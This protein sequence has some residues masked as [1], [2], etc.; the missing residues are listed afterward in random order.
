MCSIIHFLI[1][2]H[3]AFF[4]SILSLA[5]RNQEVWYTRSQ[6][7]EAMIPLGEIVRDLRNKRK[8]S[9]AQ[10]AKKIG[11]NSSTIA[12]YET[13][14][15]FPSLSALIALS[16]AL[17]VSTDYLLGVSKDEAVFLDFSGLTI[18][19]IASLNAIIENYRECNLNKPE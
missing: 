3:S 4:K 10:L 11:V 7:G 13:G 5:I 2:Y 14:E 18:N 17:G 19:Q 9:Q 6:A 8:L 16:R 15:R 12:L 1:V